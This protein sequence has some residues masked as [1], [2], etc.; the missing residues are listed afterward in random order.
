MVSKWKAK[1]DLVTLRA[2]ILKDS[3]MFAELVL[4]KD[5]YVPVLKGRVPEYATLV[6]MNTP[7]DCCKKNLIDYSNLLHL[8][9]NHSVSIRDYINIEE[10]LKSMCEEF[11]HE[12]YPFLHMK[13]KGVDNIVV[14]LKVLII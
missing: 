2:V 13:N 11:E 6:R 7:F 3:K 14:L 10:E 4:I 5:F 1:C 8:N 9:I 12:F